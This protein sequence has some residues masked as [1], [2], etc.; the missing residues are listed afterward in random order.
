[1]QGA[2]LI[3]FFTNK[4]N[5]FWQVDSTG[6]VTV[7]ANP[8]PLVYS[9]DGWQDL[10]IKNIRNKKWWATD[11]TV[12]I[13][14]KYVEDAAQ[15]LKY[16]FYNKGVE[17]STYLVICEQRLD[18]TAGVSYGYWYKQV[19]K[20]EI[21]FSTYDH[22]GA[23]VTANSVEEGFAKHLKANENT[24]YEFP[25]NVPEAVIVKDDGV[26]IENKISFVINSID[27]KSTGFSGGWKDLSTV[28]IS[29]V[30]E[31]GPSS[32][33]LVQSQDQEQIDGSTT[34]TDYMDGSENCIFR[35]TGTVPITVNIS[36][37]AKFICVS[38][39]GTVH[40]S[41]NFALTGTATTYDIWNNVNLVQGAIFEQAYAFTITLAPG[42]KLFLFEFFDNSGGGLN[43][44]HIT[45]LDTDL[46]VAEYETRFV[47]TFTKSLRPQ[48]VFE[49]LISKITDGLYQAEVCPYFGELQNFDK[50]FTS[51]NG[52]RGLAD[53]TLKISL[54]QFFSFWNTY[55]EVG[56]R[57][58][59][60]KILFDRKKALIDFTTIIDL[61]EVSGLKV[62]FD[63]EMPFN[64]LA[65]GYPDV[66]NEVG[67]TNGK[68]EFNTTFVFSL[69]T[70]KNPR[71]LEKISQ[72]Q[73]S[74]YAAEN[75]RI[76]NF[77]KDTTDNKSD[78]DPFV[79]HVEKTVT[80]GTGGDPD[81]YKLDRSLNAFITGVDQKDSVYNV[82]LSP[83][84]CLIN[85]GDFLRSSLYLCDNKTLKF[86]G[87]DRNDKMEY[88]NGSDV[89]IEK[90]D[91]PVGSLAD[92][93]FLPPILSVETDAPLDLL[94]ALDSNPL[95]IFQFTVNGDV[96][97][98]IPMENGINP[99]T[100]KKQTY[101][102]WPTADTDLTKLES[103]YG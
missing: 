65:I 66:K 5:N 42:Q 73:G 31:E 54:S 60:S 27:A 29:K 91:K 16:I 74:C 80:V 3:F 70:T 93:F 92:K 67:F 77:L 36:G 19:F 12:T 86:I 26:V 50:V 1:M 33:I 14:F 20:G 11:R 32:G 72:V 2:D 79:R 58:K 9:P 34:S 49:Q 35:N 63:K 15:I 55:D 59:D 40:F 44:A 39:T 100:N 53:A 41:L 84:R 38:K 10:G 61:G 8:Y 24:V 87:Q 94:E 85:S 102:G 25:L 69:G 96:Y 46:T 21:D 6:Q 89:I 45:Y 37:K 23:I 64:E 57:E 52:L 103:Y 62:S 68:N 51:G 82:A 13:P 83:A 22:T 75:V 56:I 101:T 28:S 95:Q 76:D 97:K 30:I 71:R 17:E 90:A 47:T 88:I 81:H 4:L 18:Y 43:L 7:N 99:K 78:N 48:Y 98:I